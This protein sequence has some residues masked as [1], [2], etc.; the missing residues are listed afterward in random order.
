MVLRR[1]NKLKIRSSFG[2]RRN[3]KMIKKLATSNF[4]HQ[5]NLKIF[6]RI[7]QRKLI[8]ICGQFRNYMNEI[9]RCFI[10]VS[11][12]CVHVFSNQH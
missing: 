2:T 8:N 3:K 10:R 6:V 11:S 1:T 9:G 7:D 4:P 12:V 5:T